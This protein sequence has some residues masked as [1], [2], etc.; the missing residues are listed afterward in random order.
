MIA[1]HDLTPILDESAGVKYM[2]WDYDQWV[3]YDD[4]NTFDLKMKF[5]TKPSLGGTM[6][7]ALE[8]D[9]ADSQS[10]QFLNSGGNMTHMNGFSIKR[11]AA[12]T[13]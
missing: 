13:Q 6:V 5:A 11:M 8:P 3:S 12:D 7:W 1:R 10:A 9:N 2:A 4:A